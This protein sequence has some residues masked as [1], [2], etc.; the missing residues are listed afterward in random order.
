MSSLIPTTTRYNIF[1][2][3]NFWTQGGAASAQGAMSAN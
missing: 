3:I 2:E 1:S